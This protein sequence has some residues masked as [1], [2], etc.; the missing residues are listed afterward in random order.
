V[1]DLLKDKV[2]LVTST[3]TLG[4]ACARALTAEGATVV[5]E[6]EVDATVER[7]GR[8]D[9]MVVHPGVV[10]ARPLLDMSLEEWR[11][12]TSA[13]LDPAFS[14]IRHAARVMEGGSIVT[15]ASVTGL[16]GTPLL[17]HYAAANAGLISLTQS[18]AA[19]LRERGIRVNAV[20]PGRVDGDP[21]APHLDP[22]PLG[23]PED[24]ARLVVFLSSDRARFC[25][26]G[27]YVADGG[28]RASLV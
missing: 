2:A 9:I 23:R 14:A 19:E 12:I 25:T 21:V 18:A 6:D 15:L 3:T 13:T 1:T 17:A 16:A 4:R 22:A 20:C 28:L 11:T 7:H 10:A 26:G 27:V 5:V 24:I 8:L